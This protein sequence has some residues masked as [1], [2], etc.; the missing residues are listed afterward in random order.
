[1]QDKV[2][3]MPFAEADPLPGPL[4]L[5][6]DAIAPGERI[7]PFEI[8]GVRLGTAICSEMMGPGFARRLVAAGATLLANP[9]NDYWFTSAAA[10]RQQLAK[11]RL[12]AIETRRAVARATSTGYS[13]LIDARGELVALSGFGDAEW[14]AGTLRAGEGTTLHQRIGPGLGP[15]ALA[16]CLAACLVR[17]RRPG[18]VAFQGGETP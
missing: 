1:V 11:A 18:P 3:P 12:R 7:R 6:R 15:G 2:E 13:A 5:G 14:L 9:S 4:A 17:R 16:A 10:A 8:G